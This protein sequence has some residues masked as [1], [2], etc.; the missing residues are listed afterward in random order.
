MEYKGKYK[1]MAEEFRKDGCDDGMIEKFIRQEMEADEY[2]KESGTTSLAAV[3]LWNTYPEEAKEMWLHNAF[4]PKCGVTS[5]K[6][7]YDL[8]KDKF[9]VVIE[10]VCIKCGGRI[11]RCCD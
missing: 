5:F 8:R 2:R 1:K 7:G 6:P 10:G 3:K 4:C 11:A 9:G